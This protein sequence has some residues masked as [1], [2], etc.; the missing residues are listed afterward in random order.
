[1]L[2][3]DICTY[4]VL[5]KDVTPTIQRNCNMLLSDLVKSNKI[6]T[7]LAKSLKC[8]TG[9]IPAFCGLLDIH[10]SGYRLRPIIDYARSPLYKVSKYLSAVLKLLTVMS[11]HSLKPS[12]SV[13]GWFTYVPFSFWFCYG[14]DVKIEVH[15]IRQR[16]SCVSVGRQRSTDSGSSLAPSTHFRLL[17]SV[18]L[19]LSNTVS[20]EEVP[21]TRRAAHLSKAFN[22]SLSHTGGDITVSLAKVFTT[23]T[24]SLKTIG[25]AYKF[26]RLTT[27]A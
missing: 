1:M 12:F 24:F 4:M 5:K 2:L 15:G 9:N 19:S 18:V 10:K 8:Y 11:V 20:Q 25:P 21:P 7:A 14:L 16:S 26:I 27:S 23:T 6:P 22:N 3:N 17:T 13:F